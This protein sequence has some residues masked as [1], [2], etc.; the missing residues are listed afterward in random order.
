LI[1][2]KGFA[3]EAQ[4]FNIFSETGNLRGVAIHN[5]IIVMMPLIMSIAC[6]CMPVEYCTFFLMFSKDI[7]ELYRPYIKDDNEIDA[8]YWRIVEL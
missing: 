7:T 3:N 1:V 6:E 8:L 4:F 2:P 5:I